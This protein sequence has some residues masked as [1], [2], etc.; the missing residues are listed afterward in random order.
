MKKPWIFQK[1][2]PILHVGVVRTSVSED[3][4]EILLENLTT[5]RWTITDTQ[6][7]VLDDSSWDWNR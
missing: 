1:E 5:G 2:E 6:G 3:G 7:D 4:K